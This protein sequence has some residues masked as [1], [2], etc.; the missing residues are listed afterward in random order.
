M[1][2][3]CLTKYQDGLFNFLVTGGVPSQASKGTSLFLRLAGDWSF[4]A[5]G[6]NAGASDQQ[7]REGFSGGLVRRSRFTTEVW[8]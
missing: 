7:Y 1:V 4:R 3:F 6:T 5:V 8:P 2:F